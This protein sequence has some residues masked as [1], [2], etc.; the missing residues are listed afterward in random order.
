MNRIKVR[1]INA[2]Q[3]KAALNNMQ[4]AVVEFYESEDK[5]FLK[6]ND[7]EN[8]QSQLMTVEQIQLQ[9]RAMKTQR[10]QANMNYIALQNN[11]FLPPNH[12]G[13]MP[14]IVPGMMDQIQ[15]NPYMMQQPMGQINL[16]P[17]QQNFM[18]GVNQ[19]FQAP[20]EEANQQAQN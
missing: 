10:Y 13:Q 19:Q 9:K 16:P 14:G 2:E 11:Y 18:P 12:Y 4:P 5:S 8:L 1:N 20:T 6:V 7:W 3:V 17:F 15:P